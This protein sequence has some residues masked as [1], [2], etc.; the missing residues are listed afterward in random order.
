MAVA[1]TG[2]QACAVGLPW[3]AMSIG[4]LVC[5]PGRICSSTSELLQ[6]ETYLSWSFTSVTLFA[7]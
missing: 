5:F 4:V 7:T 2:S 6:I 1:I 3:K